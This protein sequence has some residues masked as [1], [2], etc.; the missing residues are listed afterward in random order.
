[1]TSSSTDSDLDPYLDSNLYVYI[2]SM[3]GHPVPSVVATR[4]SILGEVGYRG[5]TNIG[6]FAYT[7]RGKHHR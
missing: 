5:T 2:V 6:T 4:K 7:M 1:M 3:F